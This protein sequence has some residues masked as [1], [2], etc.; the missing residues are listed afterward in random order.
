MSKRPDC[1]RSYESARA[2]AFIRIDQNLNV[3]EMLPAPTVTGDPHDFDTIIEQCVLGLRGDGRD[4][5]TIADVNGT[6]RSAYQQV[7]LLQ[8]KVHRYR[9]D[10]ARVRL[11][12]ETVWLQLQDLF[13]ELQEVTD[14]LEGSERLEQMLLLRKLRDRNNDIGSTETA[15]YFNKLEIVGD[16]RTLS[17]ELGDL[18]L[19]TE[20]LYGET[21]L[22]QLISLKDNEI[23]Q[24]LMRLEHAANQLDAGTSDLMPYIHAI[25][26]QLFG[27]GAY[28]DTAHQTLVLGNGGLFNAKLSA[29]ELARR[30]RQLRAQTSQAL[31]ACLKAEGVYGRALSLAAKSNASQAESV[32]QA[33]W[34]DTLV[35]GVFAG[36]LFLFLSWR[37]ARIGRGVEQQ[38]CENNVTLK[39]AMDELE[40]AATTDKLTGLL[41]RSSFYE[42]LEQTI[43]NARLVSTRFALLFLDFDRFKVVNDSLGHKVGDALLCDIANRLKGG[44]RS[45]DKLARFG[46]DEF[47]ILLHGLSSWQEAVDKA[48]KILDILAVPHQLGE[49]MVVSTASI[50]MVTNEREYDSPGEMI[51]DA[52]S[53]MYHA[54][55]NGKARVVL[56][57]K[58]MHSLALQRLSM[59]AEL[60]Q[61]VATCNQFELYYQPIVDLD[62]SQVS[63]FEALIRWQHP[64][65]GTIQPDDFVPIAED[66]GLIVEIGRWVLRT[67][68]QQLT[69]WHKEFADRVTLKMNVNVSKRQLF[70]PAFVDDVQTCLD[71]FGLDPKSFQLEIT[72]SVIADSRSVVVPQLLKLRELGLPI[73]MDDFGTGVSSLSTLHDYPIDVLKI[74]KAF[75]HSVGSDRSLLAVVVSITNLAGNLG[76]KTVA[77]GVETQDIVGALQAIGCTW[78][79]GY[80][81]AK[82]MSADDAQEY[83]NKQLGDQ[84]S[85]AA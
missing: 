39:K 56:F 49:Y 17:L 40:I 20:R 51:R 9:E 66:N 10:H 11:E 6:L 73:V 75:I 1:F 14:K 22:D 13:T 62:D 35:A 78:G 21:D 34:R 84:G 7:P 19:L 29:L 8:R 69:L 48:N 5:S 33:A 2:S 65:L 30:Q 43:H 12:L 82:P 57:D 81:F 45:A 60:R 70:D 47:V 52:D 25:Q 41:N 23:R 26:S 46:G 53:A 58:Q 44:L 67:A 38:L 59:E 15:L 61:A 83:L 79:Q 18:M 32:F 31:H 74:D 37:L 42:H 64:V 68:A 28:D 63:G 4:D 3:D 77:E 76:I 85:L 24:T 27:Q 50:G 36:V 16:L 80:C 72:E 71:D 55:E 54:K